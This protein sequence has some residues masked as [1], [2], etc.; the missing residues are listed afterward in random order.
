VSLRPEYRTYHIAGHDEHVLCFGVGAARQILIV[1]PLF[2]EMNRVRR[3]LAQAMRDLASCSV[4]SM[5]VDLPGCNES[6]ADLAL[7]SMTSWA[8]AVGA[9]ASQLGATHIASLR[10]GALV[11]HG[12]TTL[13]H[14]RLAQAKGS[15][16]LKTMLRTRI[17]GDKEAGQVTSEAEL[18]A[19]AQAG[20]IELA[21]NRLGRDM[22]ASLANAT[23]QPVPLLTEPQLG[24]DI[25]G[26]PLW[27]RAEPQDDAAMSAAIAADLDGWSA[28]CGG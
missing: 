11:D 25:A 10:G 13:P 9:A 28:A 15:S 3:M 2:D 14:W 4:G 7:Q 17:A 26:S 23:P 16:L 19:A 22:I 21:G 1:P 6:S 12:A 24:S 20:P 5:L 27:L 8:E 18:L